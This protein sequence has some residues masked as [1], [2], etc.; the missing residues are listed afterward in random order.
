MYKKLL[1]IMCI[2]LPLIQVKAS[3]TLFNWRDDFTNTSDS[4]VARYRGV[5]TRTIAVNPPITLGSFTAMSTPERGYTASVTYNMTGVSSIR[6][7]LYTEVGSFVQNDPVIGLTMGLSS[8]NN[9][10][11][12]LTAPQAKIGI[13]SSN[14]KEIFTFIDEK[15]HRLVYDMDKRYYSFYPCTDIPTGLANYGVNVYANDKA[16]R[17]E[18]INIGYNYEAKKCYEEFT[19]AIPANTTDI[20]IE[21]N[22]IGQIAQLSSSRVIYLDP[23]NLNGLAFVELSGEYIEPEEPVQTE[24]Q[25]VRPE[26]SSSETSSKT[27]SKRTPTEVKV[28]VESQLPKSDSS[29]TESKSVEASGNKTSQS[30][31]SSKSSSK[32]A[33]QSKFEGSAP[34]SSSSSKSSEIVSSSAESVLL[35]PVTYHVDK[36]ESRGTGITAA[37]IYIVLASGAILVVLLRGNK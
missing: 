12:F 28:P 32:P 37:V 31:V 23:L 7:G 15:Y 24:I 22:D 13:G 11:S 5:V 36:G 9:P 2:I 30:S 4:A 20:T 27:T 26:E 14:T 21:I 10:N 17:L 29:K 25:L 16:L 33:S 34:P 18:R 3:A 8:S 6:L 35:Q 1:L 19:A